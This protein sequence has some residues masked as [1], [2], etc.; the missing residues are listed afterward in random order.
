[1]PN[2]TYITTKAK[3]RIPNS[4]SGRSVY[5]FLYIIFGWVIATL[6][7]WNEGTDILREMCLTPWTVLWG[8]DAIQYNDPSELW[9]TELYVSRLVAAVLTYPI[10]VGFFV[11]SIWNGNNSKEQSTIALTALI[12][13]VSLWSVWYVLIELNGINYLI[14]L[15]H[16]DDDE[17][18]AGMSMA[19]YVPSLYDYMS[20]WL[21]LMLSASIFSQLPII[22]YVYLRSF[23]NSSFDKINNDSQKADVND[24]ALKATVRSNFYISYALPAVISMLF[25]IDELLTG[26]S[27]MM[28]LRMVYLTMLVIVLY[29][30]VVEHFDGVT[31]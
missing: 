29:K 11:T 19:V 10:V 22:W 25:L 12:S 16:G 28:F 9:S 31:T 6:V 30:Y 1:M 18:E 24:S 3:A 7:G 17:D 5:L 20:N 4:E 2:S 27:W 13:V 15:S 14:D 21:T 23:V 8:G 26:V